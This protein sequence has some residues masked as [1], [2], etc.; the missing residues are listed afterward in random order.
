MNIL[1]RILAVKQQ[2]IRTYES[3]I[4]AELPLKVGIKKPSLYQQLLK[5]KELQI[6]AEIKRASPSKGAIN[7]HID[8][9]QQAQS[10]EAAGASAISVLT[11]EQFFHGSIEDLRLVA[12]N[13]S[14]PVLCKDF[15]IHTSQI[16]RAYLAGASVILLIV[17]ALDDETFRDLHAYA[18]SLGLEVLVE[19]HSTQEL[20]RALALSAQL[21]GIN[22]RDLTTF[23]VDL[24]TT[25][26]IA[27]HVPLPS[28]VVFISES[29]IRS[30]ADATRVASAGVKALLVGE[31]L[32]TT[33]NVKQT[34]RSLQVPI[35]TEQ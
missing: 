4:Y 12:S 19:V 34:V 29:G 8:P 22:N 9:L 13:V 28:D 6:I 32:M 35:G 20:T 1:E 25:E 30:T 18:V 23:Q 2:E 26:D 3:P 11:D 31:T 27:G 7:E 16:D 33:A 5:A 17:A 24:Q 10:Y 14:I 15:I 21:I